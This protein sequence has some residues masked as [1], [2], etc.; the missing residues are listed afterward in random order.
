MR[1]E[2]YEPHPV[3]MDGF[4]QHIGTL[5]SK[6]IDGNLRFAFLTDRHHTNNAGAV[7][8]GVLMTLAD[9]ILGNTVMDAL[10]THRVVTVSLNCD[11]I[12]GVRPG[13]WL[14]GEAHITKITRPL[15]F[16]EGRIFN[17]RGPVLSASGLWYRRPEST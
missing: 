15:V 12:G 16:L 8:G 13:E 17:Q 4:A 9:L 10:K 14:E 3:P 5:F 7:H 6:R 1:P 2:G 11:F